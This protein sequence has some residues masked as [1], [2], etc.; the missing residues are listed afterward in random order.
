MYSASQESAESKGVDTWSSSD[1]GHCPGNQQAYELPYL[2]LTLGLAM[3]AEPVH[4]L[5]QK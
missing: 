5:Y 4:S 2:L 3:Q 1:S